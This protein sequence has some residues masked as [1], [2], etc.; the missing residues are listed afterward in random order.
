MHA[1]DGKQ[2]GLWCINTLFFRAQS[3]YVAFDLRP[4]TLD[5]RPN[6]RTY[7]RTKSVIR[8]TSS[9]RCCSAWKF[10]DNIKLHDVPCWWFTLVWHRCLYFSILYKCV[11]SLLC[12]TVLHFDFVVWFCHAMFTSYIEL[13]IVHCGNTREA[14]KYSLMY[15]I[16]YLSTVGGHHPQL[17][18]CPGYNKYINI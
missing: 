3:N 2:D 16:V 1:Q 6:Q 15:F 9:L 4:S 17:F 11:S 12:A 14:K 7:K 10:S 18:L 13:D 5:L 8:M